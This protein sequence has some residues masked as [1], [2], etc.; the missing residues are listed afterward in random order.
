[1][2]DDHFLRNAP[3]MIPP[4]DL[5]YIKQNAYLPEHLVPY[6]TVTSGGEP[7]LVDD[8]LCYV[9]GNTLIVLAYPLSGNLDEART[10]ES[11]ERAVAR[12]DPENLSII[13]PWR[14]FTAG[15]F[16]ID[17]PDHYYR[18]QLPLPPLRPKLA[19]LLRRASRDLQVEQAREMKGDHLD[20]INEFLARRDVADAT[21][22]IIARI[23]EYA[24]S[25]PSTVVFSARRAAGE[26]SAF[27]VAD[28]W[29]E[30]YAF[31]MFNFTAR[32]NAVPGASD[33]LLHHIIREA[34]QQHKVFINLGLGINPGVTFFKRKWGAEPFLG[35]HL[36]ARKRGFLRSLLSLLEMVRNREH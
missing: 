23:P 13:A 25:V 33:L 36:L 35:H 17:T 20:T 4:P 7:H 24:A 5:R 18:L 19:N 21:R 16:T 8:V 34:E 31:Y 27:S 6:V 9:R 29:A 32:A 11:L 28:F 3:S 15:S 14:G 30:R 1:M 12:F 22:V 26:L 10:R 2:L